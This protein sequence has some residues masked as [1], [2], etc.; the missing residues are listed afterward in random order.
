MVPSDYQSQQRTKSA[1][2]SH[3]RYFR[4]P[5]EEWVLSVEN[6]ELWLPPSRALRTL[7]PLRL[8]LFVPKPSRS[9]GKVYDDLQG[10]WG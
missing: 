4:H 9:A 1:D 7:A 2:T 5:K 3:A 6:V 10:S 8:R